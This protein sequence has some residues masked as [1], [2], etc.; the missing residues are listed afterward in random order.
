MKLVL[1]G[2]VAI[3]GVG[4][5]LFGTIRITNV[6]D[7]R[8]HMIDAV[9]FGVFQKKFRAFDGFIG[10]DILIQGH[11]CRGAVLLVVLIA[12]IVSDLIAFY[13]L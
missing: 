4:I 9:D 8:I 2:P 12:G 1:D 7:A 6:G 13:S 11:G 3:G 5:A 10:S